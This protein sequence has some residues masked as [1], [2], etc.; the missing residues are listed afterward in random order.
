MPYN[1]Y[2]NFPEVVPLTVLANS[3]PPLAC[4]TSSNACKTCIAKCLVLL[5]ELR[6]GSEEWKLIR[7][8][9]WSKEV[10]YGSYSDAANESP[11]TQMLFQAKPY[12]ISALEQTL[13]PF[14][15]YWI[16]KFFWNNEPSVQTSKR[17]MTVL[18]NNM[19]S[20]SFIVMERENCYN[21][22]KA[23]V[24]LKNRKDIPKYPLDLVCG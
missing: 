20:E 6:K 1:S 21:T 5:G 14:T 11:T 4:R 15:S 9:Q 7:E 10:C 16:Y 17:E 12:W 22:L 2:E 18:F 23:V 3:P 19:S 8:L 13:V 24:L